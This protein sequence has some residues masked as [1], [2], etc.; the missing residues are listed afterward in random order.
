[1]RSAKSSSKGLQSTIMLNSNSVSS[2]P[3]SKTTSYRC[4]IS[5]QAQIKA[6]QSSKNYKNN[7]HYKKINQIRSIL[8]SVTDNDIS[9]KR[10]FFN[11]VSSSQSICIR[12]HFDVTTPEIHHNTANLHDEINLDSE[13][14][15]DNYS[16][17]SFKMI[18]CSRNKL[19]LKS[20]KESSKQQ[21]YELFNIK[22]NFELIKNDS[23]SEAKKPFANKL[24]NIAMK[25][26][27]DKKNSVIN[28]LHLLSQMIQ[29]N[30]DKGK[31]DS[32]SNLNHTTKFLSDNNLKNNCFREG[33]SVRIPGK[34][35]KSSQ[36][37][38]SDVMMKVT[39]HSELSEPRGKEK[40]SKPCSSLLLLIPCG[41]NLSNA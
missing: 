40:S 24:S 22:R 29:I 9:F 5:F 16:D 17:N 28:D 3:D 14:Y 20:K 19:D 26:K 10:K 38:S 33:S 13:I 8:L 35:I 31:M 11:E 36:T 41:T 25:L 21:N 12:Q 23:G 39:S 27:G 2:S 4:S 32:S 18:Y 30:K 7:E 15:M 37:L 1:M 6:I 34:T